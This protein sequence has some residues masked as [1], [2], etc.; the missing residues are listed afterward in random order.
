MPTFNVRAVLLVKCGRY[1]CVVA[2]SKPVSSGGGLFGSDDEDDDDMF[3]TPS[4]IAS[5]PTP[6]SATPTDIQS[7]T[8]DDKTAR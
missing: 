5:K 8:K 3:F 1:N 7:I 4:N 2:P 6:V